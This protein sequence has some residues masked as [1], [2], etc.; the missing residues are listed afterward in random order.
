M[1][2]SVFNSATWRFDVYLVK[3]ILNSEKISWELR[4]VR[5]NITSTLRQYFKM[6]SSRIR[7][8]IF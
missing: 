2:A 6:H 8:S 5:V 1:D 4:A 3:T 7:E